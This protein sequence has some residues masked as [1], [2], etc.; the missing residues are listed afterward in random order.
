MR[1]TTDKDWEKRLQGNTM[2]SCMSIN[3]I[4]QMKEGDSQEDTTRKTC[5]GYNSKETELEINKVPEKSSPK[6]G[7]LTQ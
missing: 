3:Q 2:S 6:A 5:I 7:G 1:Q 4:T